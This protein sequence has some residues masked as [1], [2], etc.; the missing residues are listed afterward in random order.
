VRSRIASLSVLAALLAAAPA[1]VRAADVPVAQRDAVRVATTTYFGAIASGD[2]DQLSAIVT[3]AYRLTEPDGS[4]H[5]VAD[6]VGAAARIAL[7]GSAPQG[8]LTIGVPT[9]DGDRISETAA[10]QTF[11]YSF[12][13]GGDALVR[14]YTAHTLTLVQTADGSWRVAADH[15]SADN[16]YY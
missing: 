6:V 13:A 9:R 4:S 1:T 5:G 8:R 3:P 10:N 15:L 11:T 16:T 7:D 12:V 14:R 2:F